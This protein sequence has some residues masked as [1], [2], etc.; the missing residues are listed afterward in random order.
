MITK[1]CDKG[2]VSETLKEFGSTRKGKTSGLSLASRSW[3]ILLRGQWVS[4]LPRAGTEG[5]HR[6]RAAGR[7]K[8]KLLVALLSRCT[9]GGRLW[10]TKHVA[11]MRVAVTCQNAMLNR[12]GSLDPADSLFSR[13]PVSTFHVLAAEKVSS[14]R[15]TMFSKCLKGLWV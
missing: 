8:P 13:R 15:T 14:S 6:T 11:E 7:L 9:K 5:W 1:P 10:E 3:V 2:R 4:S 12:P